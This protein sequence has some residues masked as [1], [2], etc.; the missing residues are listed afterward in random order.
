MQY[1]D[2]SVNMQA[3]TNGAL[4]GIRVVE[5]AHQHLGPGASMFLGDMGAEVVKLET[6][7][8]GDS[9]RRLASL[10]G[11]HFLL[12]HERN[13]FTE[14]LLRNKRSMTVDLN[15]PEGRDIVHRLVE[16]ADVFVT[17][18]RPAAA[19]S[20]SSITRPFQPSTSA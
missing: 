6:R 7:D 4:S 10:W 11:Y 20:S 12:D 3:M 5:W 17:N 2:A 14:D 15:Q 19:G 13:T 8:G 16:R 1:T 9:L 18:F